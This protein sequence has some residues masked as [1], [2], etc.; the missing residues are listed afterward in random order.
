MTALEQ[1]FRPGRSPADRWA[2]GGGHYHLS[3]VQR[4]VRAVANVEVVHRP[5]V[6]VELGATAVMGIQLAS[7]MGSASL[8]CV[9][10][11]WYGNAPGV[12]RSADPLRHACW[13]G[14]SCHGGALA[15]VG[16]DPG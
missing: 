10:G 5:A 1:R 13:A 12:D 11:V 9:L 7:T 6:N 4:A 2:P 15:L 3:G 8:D 16:D 14:A